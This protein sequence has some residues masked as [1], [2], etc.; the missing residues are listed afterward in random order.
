MIS[1]KPYRLD[2]ADVELRGQ[3]FAGHL[4]FQNVAVFW[5]RFRKVCC[6]IQKRPIVR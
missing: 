6:L 1:L 4:N 5:S 2:D 3:A